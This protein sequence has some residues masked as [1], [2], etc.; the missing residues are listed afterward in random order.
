LAS[1]DQP[2]A[3]KFFD[4]KAEV[5]G[6]VPADESLIDRRFPNVV[7]GPTGIVHQLPELML[8]REE[9]FVV[10]LPLKFDRIII[11]EGDRVQRLNS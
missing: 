7:S 9:R 6:S 1:W 11:D 8:K 10:F 2:S 5:T 4:H 3:L